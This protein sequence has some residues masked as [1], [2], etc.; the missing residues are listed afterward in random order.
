MSAAALTAL[1]SIIH[2]IDLRFHRYFADAMSKIIALHPTFVGQA[3]TFDRDGCL[4]LVNESLVCVLLRMTRKRSEPE[5]WHKW[6][7][8]TGYGPC[9]HLP[10]ERVFESIDAA[11]GWVA[12]RV[13]GNPRVQVDPQLLR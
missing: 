3:G 12:T 11:A 7:L 1:Q 8:E 5:L 10:Q 2:V 13:G 9:R 6:F 4:V